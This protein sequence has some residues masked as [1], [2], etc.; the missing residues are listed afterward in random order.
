[1]QAHRQPGQPGKR[2]SREWRQAGSQASQATRYAGNATR[3]AP[4]PAR[5]EDK[6]G[7]GSD[8]KPRQP[9]KR[10]SR[11]WKHTAAGLARLKDKQ[12]MEADSSQ[13]RQANSQARKAKG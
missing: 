5:Q 13:A 10:I 2:I 12:G 8:R 1:M 4:R 11:E 9:G 3:Q 7:M 6:W